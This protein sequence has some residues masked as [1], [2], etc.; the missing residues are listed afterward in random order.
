MN[1]NNIDRDQSEI[2]WKVNLRDGKLDIPADTT[3]ARQRKVVTIT[4]NKWSK[5]RS[6]KKNSWRKYEGNG[7]IHIKDDESQDWERQ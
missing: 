4:D 7:A 3:R 1:A 2:E 5:K 6:Q